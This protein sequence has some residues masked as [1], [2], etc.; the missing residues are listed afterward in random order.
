[1]YRASSIYSVPLSLGRVYGDD[2]SARL[3]F[4]FPRAKDLRERLFGYAVAVTGLLGLISCNARGGYIALIVASGVFGALWVVRK[5]RFNRGDFGPVFAGGVAAVGFVA[6]ITMIFT[7]PRLYNSVM[8]NSYYT[9]QSNQARIDEW[10]MAIPHIAIKP[11]HGPWLRQW[12]G[13]RRLS[14]PGHGFSLARQFPDQLDR[15]DRHSGP[16][17]LFRLRSR[18]D[19]AGRAPISHRPF[20]PRRHRRGVGRGPDRAIWST[21]SCLSQRENQTLCIFLVGMVVVL[22]YLAKSATPKGLR[23]A[24]QLSRHA[25]SRGRSRN[26]G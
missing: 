24:D 4:H 16:G 8:G 14:F 13:G 11:C 23:H 5:A 3:L 2:H 25:V 7:V 21:G 12:R 26:H 22:Q 6:F 15:R 19:P 9:Q 1:M 18:G 10:N 17:P 20:A